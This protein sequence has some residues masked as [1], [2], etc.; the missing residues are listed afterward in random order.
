MIALA[1]ALWIAA[2]VRYI[3]W[4]RHPR[5]EPALGTI[6]V[7]AALAALTTS[8]TRVL[9]TLGLNTAVISCAQQLLLVT[10]CVGA[11]VVVA[12]LAQP[13]RLGRVFRR[14]AL[15]AAVLGLSV[16]VLFALGP[17]I[18]A[19]LSVYEFAAR[20]AGNRYY[21]GAFLIVQ[22]YAGLACGRVAY[23]AIPLTR[24]VAMRVPMILLVSGSVILALYA[25]FRSSALIAALTI[26]IEPHLTALF[27]V[28]SVLGAL[29]AA[30]LIASFCWVPV[31][32]TGHSIRLLLRQGPI[33]CQVTHV[34]PQL[35]ANWRVGGL[36][37][38]RRAD[39]RATAVLDF[40]TLLLPQP[41]SEAR[42]DPDAVAV[43]QWLSIPTSAPARPELQPGMLAVPV[44]QRPAEWLDEVLRALPECR[45]R[46]L[47][48][49]DQDGG[50]KAATTRTSSAR[51]ITELSAPWLVNTLAALYVGAAA[52]AL[53]WG[54]LRPS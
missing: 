42:V 36:S 35:A 25:I 13:A 9:S 40:L 37:L 24:N 12:G 52:D 30:L 48:D 14:L 45:S 54:H 4:S 22:I 16:I 44:G 31:R 33:Y 11:E 51:L 43:A 20:Y 3:R 1:G 27:K 32:R 15:G 21:G 38:S 29:G 34:D 19:G 28:M 23:F 26:D 49:L 7:L 5:V 2:A 6:I 50:V 41:V 47:Q 17:A 46:L 10:A 53:A 39:V 18:P 8:N